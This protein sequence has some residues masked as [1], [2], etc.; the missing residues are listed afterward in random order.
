M[1]QQESA[2]GRKG[3]VQTE[4]TSAGAKAQLHT[5]PGSFLW[6][7]LQHCT[8][9]DHTLLH[10]CLALPGLKP[11]IFLL[12]VTRFHQDVVIGKKKNTLASPNN[13]AAT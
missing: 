12:C 2:M 10:S 7:Q 13:D 11:K 6:G 9:K 3:Q 5:A 8:L 1:G 4:Y